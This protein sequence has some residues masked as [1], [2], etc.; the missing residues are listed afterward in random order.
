MTTRKPENGI[1]SCVCTPDPWCD[2][3]PESVFSEL[4]GCPKPA[5]LGLPCARCKV[6]YDADLDACPLCGCKWRVS[7]TP[8][9]PAVR[10]KLQAA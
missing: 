1:S 8:A 5:L 3:S 4:R 6:Y 10:P 2:E 9:S 7:P